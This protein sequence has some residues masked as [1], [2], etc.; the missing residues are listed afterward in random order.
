MKSQHPAYEK[1]HSGLY[2]EV[3]PFVKF[4]LKFT[5]PNGLPSSTIPKRITSLDHEALDNSVENQIIVI[6]ISAMSSEVFDSPW[7][8]FR[9]QTYVQIA[10]CGMHDLKIPKM[11]RTS[12]LQG[13]NKDFL[14]TN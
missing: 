8:F 12:S 14:I 7:T 9:I 6:S 1:E 5:T 3:V 11:K 10:Q 4:I 2:T 13:V